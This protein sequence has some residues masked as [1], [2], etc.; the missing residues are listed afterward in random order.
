ML[1][2]HDAPALRK[3]SAL[4]NAIMYG[5]GGLPRAAR[6]LG[7]TVE[8]ILNGC[9]YCT[10]VHSPGTTNL[11]AAASCRVRLVE[12]RPERARINNACDLQTTSPPRH[13]P[14]SVQLR[15]KFYELSTKT[16]HR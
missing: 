12:F 16:R 9:V 5:Q 8:S 6:E 11:P 15:S 7:A 13:S 4:F 3:C 10:S 2:L 1:S 14:Y